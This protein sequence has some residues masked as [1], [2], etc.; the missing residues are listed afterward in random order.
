MNMEEQEMLIDHS[1][2]RTCKRLGVGIRMDYVPPIETDFGFRS[3]IYR[4]YDPYKRNRFLT[5]ITFAVT[6]S[7]CIGFEVA[8]VLRIESA[9]WPLVCVITAGT[10][11]NLWTLFCFRPLT[12]EQINQAIDLGLIFDGFVVK[13]DAQGRREVFLP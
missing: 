9:I 6:I 5:L 10:L 8:A 11:S 13:S 12:T 3:A 7:G 4:R 2:R 1:I